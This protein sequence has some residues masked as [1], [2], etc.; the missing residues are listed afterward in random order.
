MFENIARDAQ[1]HLGATASGARPAAY[2]RL[3]LL[4]PGFQLTLCIRAQRHLGR[5]PVVGRL[6]RRICWYLTTIYFGCD[7]APE[8][9][10]GPGL[11]IPH[12]S[13]IVI[14]GEWDIGAD[15]SILQGV[16]LG[17][18]AAPPR[19]CL[20]G[21][22]VRIGAGAKIIGDI[23]IGAGA[24][25]GANAVVVKPVPPGATAVGVPARIIIKGDR[26]GGS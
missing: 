17:R 19:L 21:D 26:E 7:I 3:L 25:I 5:I 13:G 10:F 9:T 12:S 4:S 15:V 23:D 1:R 2:L 14:G 18:I 16:T 6:L 11:Y 22:N 24:R 20:V 8:A